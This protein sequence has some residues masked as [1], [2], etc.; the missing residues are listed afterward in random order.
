MRNV[1]VAVVF[2][3]TL[4]LSGC[5]SVEPA[6]PSVVYD[7]AALY[8]GYCATCHGT[9]GKGDGPVAKMLISAVPDLRNTKLTNK[10]DIIEVIDGRGIRGAHGTQDM[11]VWGWAFREVEPSEREV[12]ARLEALAD[13]T[14]GLKQ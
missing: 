3:L 4:V 10:R 2:T 11:P 6:E 1:V 14:L 12:R 7:G 9:T 8:Q 5:K 13:Y